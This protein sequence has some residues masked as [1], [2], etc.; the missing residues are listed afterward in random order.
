MKMKG[1]MQQLSE[2]MFKSLGGLWLVY[3][4]KYSSNV[5]PSKYEPRT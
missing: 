5:Y 4:I 3:S 1:G 2:S